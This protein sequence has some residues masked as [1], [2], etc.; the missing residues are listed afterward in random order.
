MS[1]YVG[2][3]RCR[4]EIREI[5]AQAEGFLLQHGRFLQREQQGGEAGGIQPR[6]DVSSGERRW[7]KD[8][9]TSPGGNQR[10]QISTMCLEKKKQAFV[11][12]CYFL[13]NIQKSSQQKQSGEPTF[14]ETWELHLWQQNRFCRAKTDRSTWGVR[15]QLQLPDVLFS[16]ISVEFLHVGH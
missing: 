14:E 12:S 5:R 15:E 6:G 13:T 2:V 3:K 8:K 16:D 4:G 10:H 7:E 1:C 11:K 9:I